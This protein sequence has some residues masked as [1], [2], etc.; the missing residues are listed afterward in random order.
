VPAFRPLLQAR[1]SR[2]GV[3]ER[4]ALEKRVVLLH[5]PDDRHLNTILEIGTDAGEI[6]DEADVVLGK[7][8]GGADA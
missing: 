4:A 8:C 6:L 1:V 3:P 2:H 5:L 7:V